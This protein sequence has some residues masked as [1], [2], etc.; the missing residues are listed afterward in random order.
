M[1]FAAA[2]PAA[3]GTYTEMQA[4]TGREAYIRY[5][6][7]CHHASLR[8][9][10]HGAP[11]TGSAF[12]TRWGGRSASELLGYVRK[13]MSTTVPRTA[14]QDVYLGIIAHILRA[15][16]VAASEVALTADSGVRVGSGSGEG[17]A[18]A[19]AASGSA[20]ADGPGAGSG[21]ERREWEGAS[22]IAEAAMRA[23]Q[24]SNRET[25]P[26]T[27]VTDQLLRDPP[28]SSWLS[29]RRT[30]DG[31]G[32]SPLDQ[33]NRGNVKRL[34]LAWAMTM[35]EGSN[36]VTPLV[37][38]GVMFLTHAANVIQAI[39]AATGDLIWEYAYQYPAEARTLGG[40]TRNIAIYGDRLFMATY[41]A[42]IVAIDARSGRQLWRSVKADYTKGYTHTA[43]PVIAGGV[44]VSGIN[45]C[46][47][48]KREGCF[49]TGHDPETGRELWRTSTI[50]LPG[51]P[52]D[53]SWAGVPP[54]LRGGADN[55]IA[56]SYDP[57]LGLYYL[58]TAQAKPW[59]AASRRMSPLDAAL[60]TNSTLAIDP[61]TGKIRWHFQHIP[62]ETLDME[63]GFERVLVDLDGDKLLLT[64]GKDGLLWKLDRSNGRFLGFTETIFQDLYAKLD[65]EKGRVHYRQ[66]I[67][68]AKVGD[69]VSVC[70]SIYG[71][72]NWQATAYSPE[73]RSLIIPLHQLCMDFIGREVE[74]VE[75][76]GGYGGESTM[77]PMPGTDGNFGRLSSFDVKTLKQRWSHVQRPMFI[78]GVLTTA[79]GLA[80]VG[81]VDRR[82]KA[83][84][85][86]T[87]KL[88]WETRLGAPPHGYPITYAVDG[89][90]Y[91]A[92]PTGMGVFKLMTAQQMPD[93]YQPSG[94][95]QLYV[96]ELAD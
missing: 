4:E 13:E 41:D 6:S 81:D 92:V 71:G 64:V 2:W 96:F 72:H 23:G 78:T 87:G 8:G 52:N 26:L 40:P 88:L 61:R 19:S 73:T 16:G 9:S 43:G 59:H 48:F 51:D 42:A 38:D 94:G 80:F 21:D 70:P 91:V 62:G 22:G 7:E 84:D 76:G 82:F 50:A 58:G 56:G 24:W 95:N 65:H 85:V 10:A 75:G 45:G 31:Q 47:R 46:E 18:V 60:Y 3:A 79:G 90:Q 28:A 20:G 55:W 29:W 63:T 69:S 44:V 86:D 74:M 35:R 12:L 1:L 15:N 11:L 89:R 36:Q 39:D 68:D 17:P 37:H 77:K 67:I 54:E 66:D 93:I 34:R 32:Y 30:L 53:A 57:E 83:F 27:P 25:K 49:I 5:C 33:V 14:D